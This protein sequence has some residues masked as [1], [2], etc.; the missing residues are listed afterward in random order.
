MPSRFSS[1]PSDEENLTFVCKLCGTKR[2]APFAKITNLTHHLR[3]HNELKDWF[4]RYRKSKGDGLIPEISDKLYN[5]IKF[6]ISTNSSLS[7]LKDEN[8]LKIIDIGIKVP[9][10]N[11]LR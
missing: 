4:L 7:I 5:F 3:D 1:L 2:L 6:F 10:Y 9:S 11:V 8:L